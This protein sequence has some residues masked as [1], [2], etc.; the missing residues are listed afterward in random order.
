MINFQGQNRGLDRHR[1]QQGA[2]PILSETDRNKEIRY[3]I[4]KYFLT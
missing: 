4:V 3:F 1:P 2:R